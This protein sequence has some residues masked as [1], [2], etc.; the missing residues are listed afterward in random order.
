MNICQRYIQEFQSILFWFFTAGFSSRCFHLLHYYFFI[1]ES[2]IYQELG[3]YSAAHLLATD[4]S[5]GR[6]LSAGRCWNTVGKA[7]TYPGFPSTGSAAPRRCAGCS[8][9][10]P[11]PRNGSRHRLHHH[12]D[13]YCYHPHHCCHNQHGPYY[14]IASWP[15]PE[16]SLGVLHT[17]SRACDMR[18]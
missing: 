18:D 12:R 17:P 9:R 11:F 5:R 1:G 8:S 6:D 13:H 15:S 16:C 7:A 2:P 10:R 3:N 14:K 4:R